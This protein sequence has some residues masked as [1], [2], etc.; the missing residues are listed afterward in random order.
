MKFISFEFS[1]K[2]VANLLPDYRH[3]SC[4]SLYYRLIT[5]N[6]FGMT[7]SV[8]YLI[9]P[10]PLLGFQSSH[11]TKIKAF[12]AFASGKFTEL[13]GDPTGKGNETI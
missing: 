4:K 13:Y 9:V 11:D 12:G 6:R 8:S 10:C 5:K 3:H 7:P 1:F 2:I